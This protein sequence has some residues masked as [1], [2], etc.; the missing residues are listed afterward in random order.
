MLAWLRET[1]GDRYLAVVSF[2]TVA[3]PAGLPADLPDVGRLLLATSPSR[4]GGGAGSEATLGL[5]DLRELR[6]APGEGLLFQ[7]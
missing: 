3:V 1:D 4:A 5:T 6:L 7:L 2:A